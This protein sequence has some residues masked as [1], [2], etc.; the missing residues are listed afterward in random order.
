MEAL[1]LRLRD[2][3]SRRMANPTIENP[4]TP[5]DR[6]REVRSFDMPRSYFANRRTLKETG[7][8]TTTMC[9]NKPCRT[10]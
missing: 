5:L 10:S 3:G 9:T 8:P 7:S 2:K 1:L 4:E 6:P